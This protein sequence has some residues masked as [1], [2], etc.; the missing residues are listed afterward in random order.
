MR[1]TLISRAITLAVAGL[2]ALGL[3]GGPAAAVTPTVSNPAILVH[4][5][6]AAGEQPENVLVE[7]D[8]NLIVSLSKAHEVE[9]VTPSGQRQLVATLPLPPDGGV[10]PPVLGFVLATGLVRPADG[11]LYVGYAAGDDNYTGIWR[12]PPGGQPQRIVPMS[13]ASFP[14]GLALDPATGLL[15]IAD[16]TQATIWRVPLSGGTPTAWAQGSLL[17]RSQRLG[18]NGLKIHNGAVWTSDSDQNT[19]LRI[20][21]GDRGAAG[22]I[23]VKATGLTFL[24]D[25][26]F[27]GN[28]DTVIGALNLGDQVVLIQPDGSHSVLL[29]ASDG[30][31]GPTSVAISNGKLYVMSAAFVL[32][33]PNILVA[34]INIPC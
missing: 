30:I 34:D 4:Y 21:M 18:A 23:E 22:P 29:T 32:Q 7:P 11:T 26:V 25:F 8:G 6:L 10:N 33:D 31:E 1:N 12:I 24:D 20:P 16:S 5:N 17:D 19:L 9:R 14:N 27:V 13:A 3:G 2:V 15:Y 28:T